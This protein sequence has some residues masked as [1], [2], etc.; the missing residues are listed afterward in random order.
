ML[1]YDALSPEVKPYVDAWIAYVENK[2]GSIDLVIEKP[3]Y[4]KYGFAGTPDRLY[5][6]EDHGLIV[7]IKT[8]SRYDTIHHLQLIAY[9]AL[10]IEAYPHI[11]E[12]E[13]EAVYLSAEGTHLS[14]KDMYR[15]ELFNDFLSCKRVYELQNL[16]S[17]N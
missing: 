16:S 4:S 6:G 11:Q 8:G 17:F 1:D 5:L 15:K 9:R 7:D 2:E 12:W 10:A 3:L 14:I 13:M